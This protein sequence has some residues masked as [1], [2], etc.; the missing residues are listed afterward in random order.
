MFEAIV[1]PEGKNL[2]GLP[3]E[4]R[5]TLEKSG[6]RTFILWKSAVNPYLPSA[7]TGLRT[8]PGLCTKEGAD[9]PSDPVIRF[10][11][12]WVM[13]MT[14][15]RNHFKTVEDFTEYMKNPVLAK[16]ERMKYPFIYESVA[17]PVFVN[18]TGEPS[19]GIPTNQSS[20]NFVTIWRG[21]RKG[22]V[23]DLDRRKRARG[24]KILPKPTAPPKFSTNPNPLLKLSRSVLPVE[25]PL[26]LYEEAVGN[27]SASIS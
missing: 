14:L 15:K 25:T 10:A 23:I 8:T 5:Q 7:L 21:K 2:E 22:V 12:S 11:L 1:L 6:A 3:I 18:V 4:A 13:E 17:H 19:S 27:F 20:A 26:D 9:P 24:N 16:G